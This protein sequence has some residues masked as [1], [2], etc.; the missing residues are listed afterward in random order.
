MSVNVDGISG[1]N[2]GTLP[3][4]HSLNGRHTVKVPGERG[5]HVVL[6][7]VA[8]HN[9]RLEPVIMID[10]KLWLIMTGHQ[11]YDLNAY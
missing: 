9:G 6:L 4:C 7:V 11:R 5:W 1:M 3:A 8:H 10:T 2:K